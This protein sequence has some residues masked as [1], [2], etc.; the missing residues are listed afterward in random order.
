MSTTA[1]QRL[2]LL[3]SPANN[4]DRTSVG[5]VLP[6]HPSVGIN[7]GIKALNSSVNI[8]PSNIFYSNGQKPYL[9]YSDKVVD[10]DSNR[11]PLI[12]KEWYKT[13]VLLYKDMITTYVRNLIKTRQSLPTSFDI[14]HSQFRAKI[15]NLDPLLIPSIALNTLNLTE[16][17]DVILTPRPSLSARERID[18]ILKL[19]QVSP[20]GGSLI[21]ETSGGVGLRVD[22]IQFH[23]KNVTFLD[24]LTQEYLPLQHPTLGR[25]S[26]G[27]LTDVLTLFINALHNS[28][29]S[30]DV[31]YDNDVYQ[32]M[33]N[34]SRS[35]GI[36]NIS[37]EA[38]L[39]WME[40]K[41]LGKLPVRLGEIK[42]DLNYDFLKSRT[43]STL[44]SSVSTGQ[45]LQNNTVRGIDSTGAIYIT[46][47]AYAEN[48]P[49][50]NEFT[51]ISGLNAINI[52]PDNF[53]GLGGSGQRALI[54]T[55]IIYRGSRQAAGN[56]PFITGLQSGA[57]RTAG[58]NISFGGSGV[59]SNWKNGNDNAC[60]LNIARLETNPTKY[61]FYIDFFINASQEYVYNGWGFKGIQ[62]ETVDFVPFEPIRLSNF[63]TH[64]LIDP[65]TNKWTDINLDRLTLYLHYITP[66]LL[67]QSGA[68]LISYTPETAENYMHT[69]VLSDQPLGLGSIAGVTKV[70]DLSKPRTVGFVVG[71]ET[72]TIYGCNPFSEKSFATQPQ[73]NS[74]ARF[75]GAETGSQVELM[76]YP[77][78]LANS[79]PANFGFRLYPSD[80]PSP[81]ANDLMVYVHMKK[82]VPA[83]NVVIY[84]TSQPTPTPTSTTPRR[85]VPVNPPS[86]T[87]GRDPTPTRT[88]TQTNLPVLTPLVSNPFGNMPAKSSS[89][90]STRRNTVRFDI[91]VGPL[92][93]G[94]SYPY[95]SYFYD[96]QPG[97]SDYNGYSVIKN[98]TAIYHP[99]ADRLTRVSTVSTSG[100]VILSRMTE[101]GQ[102]YYRA[103][104]NIS[105]SNTGIE[106]SATNPVS[107]KLLLYR[108]VTQ[109][110]STGSQIVV[111]SRTPIAIGEATIV[112]E[113]VD[114]N[115][116][117]PT[118][119]RPND[120]IYVNITVTEPDS[121]YRNIQAVRSG[122]FTENK[123]LS[124][125]SSN[126]P[127]LN[128]IARYLG[129][130]TGDSVRLMIRSSS[131]SPYIMESISQSQTINKVTAQATSLYGAELFSVSISTEAQAIAPTPTPTPTITPSIT[132][133][134]TQTP[135]S[136]Y[137]PT[138]T[139]TITLTGTATSTPTQTPTSTPTPT[140]TQTPTST[141]S[142]TPTNTST[143][144]PTIT[145]TNSP[146]YEA[147]QTPTPTNTSTITVTPT[148]TPTQTPSTSPTNTPTPSL[149]VSPSPTVTQ[150]PTNTPTASITRTPTPTSTITVTPTN[151]STVTPTATPTLTLTSTLTSTP[152]SSQTPTATTTVSLSVSSTVTPT[153]TTTIT[154]TPLLAISPTP[155]QTPTSTITTTPT[156]TPTLTESPTPTATPSQTQTLTSTPTNTVTPTPTITDSPTP[157]PTNTLTATVTPTVTRTA[158]ATPSITPSHSPTPSTSAS[159]IDTAVQWG[160]DS[161]A[162]IIVNINANKSCQCDNTGI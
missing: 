1:Q 144:T 147:T 45:S 58:R 124:F 73:L 146:F 26:S 151:T 150:T 127:Y 43:T 46:N 108:A 38:N 154:E 56:I 156:T 101:N 129:A 105:Y 29:R 76:I 36:S 14:I 34:Y 49:Q 141:V 139:T 54:K 149:S 11:L 126:I 60:Y 95:T 162:D 52:R 128:S 138:P 72:A 159:N 96:L 4:I 33:L 63:G 15:N 109:Q 104:L 81:A 83:R 20:E 102:T 68:N 120:P 5:T 16:G 160:V 137:S 51:N 2:D 106:P 143:P 132:A 133:T 161:S 116:I 71:A 12:T 9:V 8:Q 57:V 21:A 111:D 77:V 123:S 41:E 82:Y 84:T 130:E 66:R 61:M 75:L 47:L 13:L 59:H 117:P 87:T 17:V 100:R 25:I 22:S 115:S 113:G 158:T 37:P 7:V 98:N 70:N 145:P 48:Q 91:S 28:I 85:I 131:L 23:S 64:K 136:T 74:I 24:I 65:S 10:I 148:T 103:S 88:P 142:L 31:I 44:T 118:P 94:T 62:R 93:L 30:M 122:F 6:R 92:P 32:W 121:K 19:G 40:P 140:N 53:R 119:T 79:V 35:R 114:L 135:T 50:T 155:T 157:T 67:R 125:L 78:G 89:R 69:M 39:K 55:I 112:P 99:F 42:V 27:T 86:S 90:F 134:S 107:F 3:F 80:P 110:L 97:E 18:S 153:P 152:T